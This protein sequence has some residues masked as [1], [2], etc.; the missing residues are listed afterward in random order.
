MKVKRCGISKKRSPLNL[1][2]EGVRE[3]MQNKRRVGLRLLRRCAGASV[4][5]FIRRA[6]RAKPSAEA[7]RNMRR[8]Y[9]TCRAHLRIAHLFCLPNAAQNAL[10]RVKILRLA[11]AWMR[12]I[13]SRAAPKSTPCRIQKLRAAIIRLCDARRAMFRARADS[14][15]KRY[16][17]M[18][19]AMLR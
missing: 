13:K 10:S 1:I 6:E 3:A 14:A 19:R 11:A 15:S 9:R 12:I 5:K 18:R 7:R 4:A 17:N 16:R 2:R 8:A